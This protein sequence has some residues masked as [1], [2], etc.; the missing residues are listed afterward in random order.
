MAALADEIH[1]M[2][3]KFG[4]YST[5]WTKS[6]AGFLGGSAENPEGRAGPSFPLAGPR[7]GSAL[8][9]AVGRYGFAAQDARQW[10][11]WGSTT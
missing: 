6:Y 1:A 7:D 4:I 5:P 9:Y 2:G 10:A 11:A 8:P 3:L